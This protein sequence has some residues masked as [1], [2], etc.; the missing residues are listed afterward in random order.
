MRNAHKVLAVCVV[1]F[2]V[3][4]LC[5]PGRAWAGGGPENVAVVING[6]SWAS[7]AVANEFIHLRNVP[8]HNV[9][10]L[11]SVPD[12]EQISVEDFRKNI[13][14]PVLTTLEHRGLADQIDY[15]I[16][17]SDIPT[18]IDIQSDLTREAMAKVPPQVAPTIKP[19]GSINGLT[20]LYQ[21]VL[22]KDIRYVM[23]NSNFYFRPMY[24]NEGR[25]DAQRAIG[26]R[27]AFSWSPDGDIVPQGQGIGY[28][29]SGVLAVTS[30]RG[31]SV[32]EAIACLQSA[33]AADGNH[34]KGNIYFLR[35]G[36]IR[37][38]VRHEYF[39]SAVVDLAALGEPAQVLDGI[40]PQGKNDVAGLM[41]GIAD[42]DWKASGSTILPGAICEH[43]TS[44]G[45]VMKEG[46]SQTP[47]TDFIRYGAAG[48]SGTVDEP[49]A[50]AQKFPT[51]FM[52]VQYARGCSLLEAYYQSVAAPYQLLIV[53]D[54]LCQ[55][56]ARIPQV[57]YE[58]KKAGAEVMD[59]TNV[60]GK[61]KIK[62]WATPG[63]IPMGR[64]ELFVDGARMAACAP[65]GILDLDTDTLVEGYHEL[66][67][68]GVSKESP[69]TQGREVFCIRVDRG[70][71][72][73]VVT[74]P[75]ETHQTWDVP[76]KLHAKLVGAKKIVF[77]SN[78]RVVG[79]IAAP[80]GAAKIDLR[81]LGQGPISLQPV[82][83]LAGADGK[84]VLVRADPIDMEVRPPM[85]AIPPAPPPA[86]AVAKGVLVVLADG[87]K[88]V[89]D[90][91]VPEWLATCGVKRDQDFEI[92]ACFAAPDDD[93]YQ[94]QL[95][96]NLVLKIEVDSKTLDQPKE[97]D[98]KFI[99]VPLVKGMHKF[100]IK[101]KGVAGPQLDL[102]FGG[103]GAYNIANVFKHVRAPGEVPMERPAGK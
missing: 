88:I 45:G 38:K 25:P 19:A 6:D 89:P 15:I 30:G 74:R 16:Y 29:L 39:A 83:V 52:Q 50:I 73:L 97:G 64:F 96:T 5:H 28:M 77:L 42:F 21:P 80:E 71:E 20:Y 82:G 76:L 100:L 101:G 58:S 47:L 62:A 40:L 87:R 92:Q 84:D 37:S 90:K 102:R 33:A 31:N 34:P 26:F 23:L 98:W 94:F 41:T 70:G 61:L 72:K 17:S 44:W 8:P 78:E 4:A 12:F 66:R 63:E 46:A 35:N 51:P 2:A 95:K 91:Y 36:D 86:D 60:R 85:P 55:P 69:M 59:G 56:W 49:L 43:F 65:G 7:L 3:A 24:H 57:H 99:P 53:G 103:P 14:Q 67:V 32:R 79:E 54:P 93:T 11:T 13:L 48:S 68:V 75:G 27:S 9:V 81:A 18:R 22:A 1:A 10:Y